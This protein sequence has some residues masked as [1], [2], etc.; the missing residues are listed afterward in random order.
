MLQGQDVLKAGLD[1]I[2]TILKKFEETN[3]SLPLQV[4]ALCSDAM[5]CLFDMI[6]HC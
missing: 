5:A 1:E 2:L 3:A 4:P 6:C